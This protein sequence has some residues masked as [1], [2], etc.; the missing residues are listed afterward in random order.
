M[1][2]ALPLPASD[3][4][5]PANPRFVAS[6]PLSSHPVILLDVPSTKGD[7][8]IVWPAR[9]WSIGQVPEPL[10]AAAPAIVKATVTV[11]PAPVIVGVSIHLVLASAKM[12]PKV[13]PP[14][15]VN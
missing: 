6:E 1:E 14:G 10:A 11:L 12:G 7:A 3:Y 4:L 2:I 8:K 9:L 15:N 13:A 5:S